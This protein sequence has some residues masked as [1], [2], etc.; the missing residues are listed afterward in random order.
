VGLLCAWPWC[1]D[2]VYF[3]GDHLALF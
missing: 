1:G 3:C 2:A